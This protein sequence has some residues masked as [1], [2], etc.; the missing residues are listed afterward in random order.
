MSSSDG[1]DD[2]KTTFGIRAAILRHKTIIRS[3][4]SPK[5]QANK[6]WALIIVVVALLTSF[7]LSF[8]SNNALMS[9]SLGSAFVILFVFILIGI[10]FDIVGTAVMA[11]SLTPFNSMAAKK[12]PGARYALKII[13]AA[14]KVSNFCNDVIGDIAGIISGSAVVVVVGFFSKTY[15]WASNEVLLNL[16]LTSIVAALTI[17]GKAIGKTI[18]MNYSNTIIYYVGWLAEGIVRIFNPESLNRPN[19]KKG[20]NKKD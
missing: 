7:G 12:V 11:A 10:V 4:A 2:N 13:S 1:E 18:A 16:I 9:V 15:L 5:R 3:L 17:G 20:K 19:K 6:K 14:S 8:L